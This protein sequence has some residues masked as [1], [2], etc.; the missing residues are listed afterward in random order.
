MNDRRNSKIRKSKKWISYWIQRIK[1]VYSICACARAHT[2]AHAH[3]HVDTCEPR[4][5]RREREGGG[6][7]KANRTKH[8][9]LRLLKY[10]GNYGKL[11][12]TSESKLQTPRVD[13]RFHRRPGNVGVRTCDFR[14]SSCSNAEGTR[15]VWAPNIPSDITDLGYDATE[16]PETVTLLKART[17]TG[18][19]QL[20]IIVSWNP[21]TMINKILDLHSSRE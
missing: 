1:N 19:S 6:Y 16:V 13:I 14:P 10:L 8:E 2:C 15:G 3:A 20:T 18:I 11:H 7:R 9:V 21:I 5:L 4:W 17:T 12:V